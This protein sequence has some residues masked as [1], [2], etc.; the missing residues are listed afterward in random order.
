MNKLIERKKWQRK[1]D[2]ATNG[3]KKKRQQFCLMVF[4]FICVCV[5]FCHVEKGNCIRLEWKMCTLENVSHIK[6]KS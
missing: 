2:G 6:M 5:L 3:E 4:D 1:N